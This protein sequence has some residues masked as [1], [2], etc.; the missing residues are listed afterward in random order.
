MWSRKIVVWLEGQHHKDQRMG[1][2]SRY[3]EAVSSEET[4]VTLQAGGLSD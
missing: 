2:D 1:N 4:S 3:P